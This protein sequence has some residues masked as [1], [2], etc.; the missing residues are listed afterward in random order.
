MACQLAPD[1]T[2]TV[3]FITSAGAQITVVIRSGSATA[4]ITAAILNGTPLTLAGGSAVFTVVAGRNN[5]DLSL[6]GSD[7][8]EDFE[9]HEDGGGSTKLMRKGNFLNGPTTGFR[10]HAF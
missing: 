1:S 2:G 9:I 6:A 5:F 7:P 10:I 4:R 8:T 3:D